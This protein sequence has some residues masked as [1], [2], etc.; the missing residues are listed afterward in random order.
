MRMRLRNLCGVGL[1][2]GCMVAAAGELAPTLDK[3]D[4]L[5][6]MHVGNSHSHALR[7]LEPLAWAVGH[8]KHK[9]GEINILGSPLRWNWDHPQ[10]NKWP[11][12]LSADKS[13]DAITLLAWASDDEGYAVKFAAEAIKGNPKCQVLI[14]TIW[15]DAHMDWDNPQP[16][17]TEGHTEKVAAAVE[18]AFPD[19]PKPRVIPS[20]LLIRELGRLADSGELPGVANRFAFFSD[21]GH[22]SETGM[23]AIDVLICAMLYNEPP[24]DYPSRYGR[25]DNKGQFVKGWYESLDIAE[26]TARIIRQVAWDVLLT[27]PPAGLAKSLVIADRHLPPAIANQPYRA[28]LKALQNQGPCRWTVV[29]GK[30]P[31]GFSLSAEGLLS[32]ATSAAGLYPLRIEVKDGK[33]SF[34]RALALRVSQDRPPALGALALKQIA[35]DD[36]FFQELK[37]DGGVGALKWDVSDGKLPFGIRLMPNGILLGTPGEAGQFAFMLRVTDSHPA[38]A[39]QAAQASAWTIGPATPQALLVRVKKTA[40]GDRKSVV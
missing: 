30:L 32:G 10:Q 40:P 29:D 9:D 8:G 6:V 34:G 36:C 25:K 1:L 12:K 26:E 23:Y 5:K 2:L 33:S 24:L 37:C 3:G 17:R 28:E 13:W 4:G 20:S 27:Y 31:Q 35:L 14:Y 18:K 38:G 22:L 19:A 7:F 16:V 15:P 21:G 39:R 11:E